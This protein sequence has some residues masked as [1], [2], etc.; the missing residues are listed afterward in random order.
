LVI[1]VRQFTYRLL[2]PRHGYRE[3]GRYFFGIYIRTSLV[4]PA[5]GVAFSSYIS[6]ISICRD[7]HTRGSQNLVRLLRNEGFYFII[8]KNI[9][10]LKMF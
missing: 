9:M 1:F 2:I 6:L 8:F 3:E 7:K 10:S 5:T 4:T